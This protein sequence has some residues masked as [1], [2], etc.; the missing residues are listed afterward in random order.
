[1]E[2]C[3]Q[4]SSPTPWGPAGLQIYFLP[5]NDKWPWA[6]DFTLLGQLGED[7]TEERCQRPAS[8][9]AVPKNTARGRNQKLMENM[10]QTTPSQVLNRS[11][12]WDMRG[13]S[14][15]LI[16]MSQQWKPVWGLDHPSWEVRIHME[17]WHVAG[18]ASP[19]LGAYRRGAEEHLT[20]CSSLG[21]PW[22]KGWNKAAKCIFPSKTP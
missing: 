10:A 18:L 19:G 21:R 11:S 20:A 17:T 14:P 13:M 5:W 3:H 22:K 8:N 2:W 6:G 9:R 4:P 16:Y 12:G 15:H 7:S 1:M